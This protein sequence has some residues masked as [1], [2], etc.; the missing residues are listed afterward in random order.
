MTQ[1]QRFA[2]AEA[3]NALEEAKNRLVIVESDEKDKLHQDKIF[4]CDISIAIISIKDAISD[5]T[6]IKESYL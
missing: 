6:T 2:I 1:E 4:L 5:V 3:L